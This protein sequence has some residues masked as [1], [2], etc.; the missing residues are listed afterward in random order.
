LLELN[1]K[2]DDATNW[3]D[4]LHGT[5]LPVMLVHYKNIH[6]RDFMKLITLLHH[7]W[8]IHK[9]SRCPYISLATIIWL[10]LFTTPEDKEWH[11]SYQ[12]LEKFGFFISHKKL[13]ISLSTI[14]LNFFLINH[15]HPF[16]YDLEGE[17][18]FDPSNFLYW[19]LLISHFSRLTNLMVWIYTA[20]NKQMYLIRNEQQ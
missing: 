13:S 12:Q 16:F 5:K 17:T 2:A 11:I 1:R 6:N 9:E 3:E 7:T 19:S 4:K 8:S 18:P 15:C 14:N 20:N 10:T